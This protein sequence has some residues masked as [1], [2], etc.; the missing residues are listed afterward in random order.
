MKRLDT[1]CFKCGNATDGTKCQWVRE[2]KPIEDWVAVP[3]KLIINDGNIIRK[4]DSY[5]VLSCPNFC[6]DV[7][8]Q[9]DWNETTQDAFACLL[10]DIIVRA[11]KDW[12]GADR[13]ENGKTLSY[14]GKVTTNQLVNMKKDVEDFFLSDWFASICDMDGAEI[15]RMLRNGTMNRMRKQSTKRIGG[16]F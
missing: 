1:L 8:V 7:K 2:L 6:K 3:T 11:I 14:D 10:T 4:L 16:G 5:C 13:V 9:R 15:V 12:H